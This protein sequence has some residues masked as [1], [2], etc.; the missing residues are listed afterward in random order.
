M[1]GTERKSQEGR[2]RTRG[3]EE[4]KRGKKEKRRAE[5]QKHLKRE[6][7]KIE[8]QLKGLGE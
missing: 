4:E 2:S 3:K 5:K 1:G 7:L 6:W 8:E